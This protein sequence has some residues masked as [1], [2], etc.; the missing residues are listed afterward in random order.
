MWL[1]TNPTDFMNPSRDR[2]RIIKTSHAF[3]HG[4]MGRAWE[5]FWILCKVS[6]P[7]RLSRRFPDTMEWFWTLWKVSIHSWKFADNLESLGT[8]WKFS[9]LFVRKF[10]AH[11]SLLSGSFHVFCLWAEC[12]DHGQV[13]LL[14]IFMK[15]WISLKVYPLYK[16][17]G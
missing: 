5:S 14:Y 17:L 12:H 15:I 11:Q 13:L 3:R 10:F 4:L 6:W 9:I 16:F 8:L 1:N 2:S 7:T